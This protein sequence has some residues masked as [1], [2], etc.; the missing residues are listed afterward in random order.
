[1]FSLPS[2][3]Q[4]GS[5]GLP[6]SLRANL[7]AGLRAWSLVGPGPDAWRPAPFQLFLLLGLDVLVAFLLVYVPA[8]GVGDFQWDALP[9]ALFPLPLVL[10][11]GFVVAWRARTPGLWLPIAT[12]VLGTLFWLDLA[13][14]LLALAQTTGWLGYD[15]DAID[16]NLLLFV[17]WALAAGVA[18]ARLSR[19][20]FL[21]R[22][23]DLGWTVVLVVLPLW[24]V[25]NALLWLEPPA[26]DAAAD[27]SDASREDVIYSQ[28][29]LLRNQALRLAPERPGV[30]DVFFVGAAGFA[31]ED[32]FLN[33]VTLAADMIRTRY[34]ADGHIA[35]LSNNPRTVDTLPLASATSLAATLRAVGRVMDPAEDILF[36]FV[37]THGSEDHTLA[38]EYWPLQLSAITPAMLSSM[39]DQA[40][41]RWR[42]IVLSACYA[43]G[44]VK[45]LEN[46]HTMII[47]AADASHQSFG[48][49]ADSDLTYFGKA[50]FDEALRETFSFSGAFDL[51]RRTIR[52]RE[53][54][55]HFEASNPEMFIGDAIRPRLERLARRMQ[56]RHGRHEHQAQCGE[57][58]A[59]DG[60]PCRRRVVGAN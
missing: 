11:A 54:A 53:R 9:R 34:D 29:R 7:L 21:G 41:I 10:A 16:W 35:L 25:P 12:A 8:G 44:F 2:R 59:P 48:C 40:G 56:A 6:A 42:V 55:N 57:P 1:M 20:P 19:G 4:P 31:E 15:P 32:V 26:D 36:L 39:L 51:A 37:T 18:V 58:G 43:G 13:S 22:V 23:A 46:A 27:V 3:N 49:G 24:W 14:N 33:E 5:E 38:M 30:E 47:T 50:Y 45:P 60:A 52:A 28:N 17:W